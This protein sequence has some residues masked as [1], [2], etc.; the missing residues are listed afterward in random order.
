[1]IIREMSRKEC[2][3]TLAGARLARLACSRDDRPYVV[4]VYVACDEAAR[5]LYGFTT[6]GQKI[7]WMRANPR[8]CV[9]VDEVVADDQWVSVV[10]TGS[11]EELP[12]RAP[13]IPRHDSRQL[14]LG[15]DE[16][17]DDQRERAWE[18][19]KST[20][21]LWWEPGCAAWAARV[22]R[23]P[24]AP[25]VFVYYR[26]RIGEVSGYEATPDVRD[27]VP[28]AEAPPDEKR[29]WLRMLMDSLCNSCK[30][31][32]LYRAQ[33]PRTRGA[34]A[35]VN[36]ERKYAFLLRGRTEASSTPYSSS[37]QFQIGQLVS[38]AAFGLG[39]VTGTRDNVKIDICFAEGE[40]VLQQGC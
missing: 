11:Y 3:Q 32:H 24:T 1:M 31:R 13:D 7:E 36:Q 4:P 30:G 33:Q 6:P 16:G 17:R 8:V 29:S 9:E 40:K 34:A 28:C 5:C 22:H 26:I 12:E 35:A 37:A 27:A 18:L 21:P 20:H 38:H 10:A 23:G 2:F 14:G 19:L 15:D 39:V 25:L